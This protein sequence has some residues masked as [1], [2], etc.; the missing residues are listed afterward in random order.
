MNVH[1]VTCFSVLFPVLCGN[2]ADCMQSCEDS[3]K[4]VLAEGLPSTFWLGGQAHANANSRLVAIL[5]MVC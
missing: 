4:E 1:Q 3:G 5:G 2:A